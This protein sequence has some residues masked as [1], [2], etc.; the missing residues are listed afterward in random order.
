MPPTRAKQKTFTS[1]GNGFF[2]ATTQ[3][4]P[5]FGEISIIRPYPFCVVC[6]SD[7]RLSVHGLPVTTGLLPLSAPGLAIRSQKTR[8]RGS[9]VTQA[10][11]AVT[12][13]TGF[14]Y[15]QSS[16]PGFSTIKKVHSTPCD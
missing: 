9:S 2:Q 10:A 16:K 15:L 11:P 6:D 12:T 4:Q 14:S 13:R 8:A 5:I 1:S 3:Y 7:F